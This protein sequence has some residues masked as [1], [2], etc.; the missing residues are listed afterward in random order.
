MSD[1]CKD[2]VISEGTSITSI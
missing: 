2:I 1:M